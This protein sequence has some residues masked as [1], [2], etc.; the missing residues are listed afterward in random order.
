MALIVL[1]SSLSRRSGREHRCRASA[2]CG[3]GRRAR[4][5]VGW[6]GRLDLL[7][8]PL[9]DRHP[10]A[11]GVVRHGVPGR[12]GDRAEHVSASRRR[13][14]Q[15]LRHETVAGLTESTIGQAS[16][17]SAT[18][19]STSAPPRDWRAPLTLKEALGIFRRVGARDKRSVF[20]AGSNPRRLGHHRVVPP[21]DEG[22]TARAP[23]DRQ[24]PV[25]TAQPSPFRVKRGSQPR[26]GDG[27]SGALSPIVGLQPRDAPMRRGRPRKSHRGA[28][29]AA[30]P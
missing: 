6:A 9:G 7:H 23:L 24:P 13:P 30:G 14:D 29:F 20:Y 21:C 4:L 1:I 26:K 19:S 15:P 17:G 12:G 25:D 10:T 27:S 18:R 3:C 16:H 5:S 11:G 22:P 2:T 28:S 8:Q